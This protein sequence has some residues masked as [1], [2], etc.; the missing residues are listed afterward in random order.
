MAEQ[1]GIDRSKRSETALSPKQEQ[2]LNEARQ[3]MRDA[4]AAIVEIQNECTSRQ[5]QMGTF[6][7]Y[8]ETKND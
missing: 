5:A 4:R 2:F 1:S 7:N 3:C 8:T 6:T